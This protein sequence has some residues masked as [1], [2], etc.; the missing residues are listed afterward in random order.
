M[1][2]K[3]KERLSDDLRS[4]ATDKEE[5]I[6]VSSGSRHGASLSAIRRACK[7]QRVFQGSFLLVPC[8][9]LLVP[10]SFALSPCSFLL[11]PC[12]SS[13][14]LLPQGS[15]SL[16]KYRK[17]KRDGVHRRLSQSLLPQGGSSSSR[18]HLQN[19]ESRLTPAQPSPI[20]GTPAYC[21][22]Q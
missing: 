4:T 1:D 12:T 17:A 10:F 3:E 21:S 22:P 2:E 19:Q 14:S 20:P 18:K 15:S 5:H 9:L 13:Q 16:M 7:G 6:P 11:S 8:T